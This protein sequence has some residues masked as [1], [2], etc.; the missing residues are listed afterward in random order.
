M[1]KKLFVTVQPNQGPKQA[2]VVTDA[3]GRPMVRQSMRTEDGRLVYFDM[4][5]GEARSLASDLVLAAEDAMYE[6]LD[7][8]VPDYPDAR[9]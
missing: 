1:A 3:E 4:T 2:Y 6:P 5:P 7:I 8:T 9:F